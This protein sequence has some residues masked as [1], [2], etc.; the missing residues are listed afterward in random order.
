MK[1]RGE[2]MKGSKSFKDM[3]EN[4]RATRRSKAV[5][6]DNKILT[7]IETSSLLVDFFKANNDIFL[8]LIKFERIGKC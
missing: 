6:I 3:I 4:I 7:Q 5:G 2:T 1:E 8:K